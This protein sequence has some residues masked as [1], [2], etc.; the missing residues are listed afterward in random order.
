MKNTA[1]GGA[2]KILDAIK[3]P[4]DIVF[5]QDMHSEINHLSKPRIFLKILSSLINSKPERIVIHTRYFL[6]LAP[7]TTALGIRTIFYCHASYRKQNYLFKVFKCNG[8]ICVSNSARRILE[9]SGVAKN[10]IKVVP[11]PLLSSGKPNFIKDD[12]NASAII[13]VGSLAPWKGYHEALSHLAHYSGPINYKI[14]GE[15]SC[16]QELKRLA[17]TLPSNIKVEFLGRLAT[18][19]EHSTY[20]PIV[21]IP[22]LEEGFG[23]VAIEAIYNGRILLYSDIPALK[24]I[25]ESDPLSI[26]FDVSSSSSFITALDQAISLSN[27]TLDRKS[28]T[29]RS[30]KTQE[31]YN[32][33][34]FIDNYKSTINSTFN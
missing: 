33:K 12:H 26:P 30:L 14:I 20:A 22:S 34:N 23:L 1:R 24:E 10:K 4:S 7:I 3:T 6:V 19:Y 15:G 32:L 18:P 13:S 21:L 29:E 2:Q 8:Y 27:Q 28:I 11:N 25:C 16:E 17:M 5:S 31:K 9:S